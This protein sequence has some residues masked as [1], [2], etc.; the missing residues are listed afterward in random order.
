MGIFYGRSMGIQWA[1]DIAIYHYVPPSNMLGSLINRFYG[2]SETRGI[3]SYNGDM[4]RIPSG[5]H[6]K[7]DGTSSFSMGKSTISMVIQHNIYI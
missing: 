6:T 4:V 3:H 2:D 7:N 1:I 5:K